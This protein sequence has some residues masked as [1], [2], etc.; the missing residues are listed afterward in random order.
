MT[1]T[2][3]RELIANTVERVDSYLDE[4]DRVNAAKRVGPYYSD[5]VHGINDFELRRSDLRDLIAALSVALDENDRLR[6]VK[7]EAWDEDL[8]NNAAEVLSMKHP[9]KWTTPERAFMRALIVTPEG[10]V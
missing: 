9:D 7:A 10:E 3:P 8:L 4:L 5:E 2:T 6:K 1:D